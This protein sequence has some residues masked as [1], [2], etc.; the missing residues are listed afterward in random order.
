MY[1]TFWSSHVHGRKSRYGKRLWW[2]ELSIEG[3]LSKT[4]LSR[5]KERIEV[6]RDPTAAMDVDAVDMCFP[7]QGP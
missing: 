2:V 6:D 7:S 4:R 1:C 3:S 5:L